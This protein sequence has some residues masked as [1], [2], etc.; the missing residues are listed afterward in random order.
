MHPP[1]MYWYQLG[2]ES[3]KLLQ[4]QGWN[5]IRALT[6]RTMESFRMSENEARLQDDVLVPSMS[7]PAAATLD[8]EPRRLCERSSLQLHPI[9]ALECATRK[10]SNDQRSV[11]LTLSH[12]VAVP[13][14]PSSEAR[15]G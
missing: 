8:L 14:V 12:Q 1:P 2:D 7:T 6:T 13:F 3:L 4:H 11:A 15:R 10:H 5:F 9:R